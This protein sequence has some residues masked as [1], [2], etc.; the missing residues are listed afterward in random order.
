MR[1]WSFL[2]KEALFVWQTNKAKGFDK[3]KEKT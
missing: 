3:K 1:A 2:F